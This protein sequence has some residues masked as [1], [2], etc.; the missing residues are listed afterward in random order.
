MI[1]GTNMLKNTITSFIE[2]NYE[3]LVGSPA[4]AVSTKIEKLVFRDLVCT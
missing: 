2:E 4:S 1:K 3:I